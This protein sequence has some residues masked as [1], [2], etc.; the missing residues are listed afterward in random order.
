MPRVTQEDVKYL[1]R[2]SLPTLFDKICGQ[3]I[4]ER[5]S[6][7][8]SFILAALRAEAGTRSEMH[9]PSL[10]SGAS[11]FERVLSIGSSTSIDGG[12]EHALSLHNP[13]QPSG[14]W[15]SSRLKDA[16]SKIEELK[17]ACEAVLIKRA[18]KTKA[19]EI[20]GLRVPSCFIP[21]LLFIGGYFAAKKLELLQSLGI[22]AMINCVSNLSEHSHLPSDFLRLDLAAEDEEDYPLLQLH[23]SQVLAFVNRCK[24]QKRRV[25]LHCLV[26]VNR[27]AA[28]G[29]ALVRRHY[30]CGI[31]EAVDR[32]AEARPG[33]L[34]NSSFLT[35]LVQDSLVTRL[36]SGVVRKGGPPLPP[37]LGLLSPVPVTSGL[38]QQSTAGS[39]AGGSEGVLVR[40]NSAGSM[41][42]A[43][44][45]NLTVPTR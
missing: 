39:D 17:A 19:Q 28:L 25:F 44:L 1:K 8:R 15:P 37:D 7:A 42:F 21:D 22:S 27:S 24:Q 29:V 20:E 43:A 12:H 45:R 2:H 6:D 38:A 13:R 16:S 23:L 18:P 14:R 26:G 41:Q 36:P 34:T 5:P 3:L 9:R 31:V 40:S 33:I 32:C 11:P 35:Q 10:I 30:E 4:K